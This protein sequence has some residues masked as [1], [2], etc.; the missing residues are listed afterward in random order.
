M[1]RSLGKSKDHPTTRFWAGI[2]F[3][4]IRLFQ[5]FYY[6]RIKEQ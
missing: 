1:G 2:L 5:F 4:D 6:F 3:S